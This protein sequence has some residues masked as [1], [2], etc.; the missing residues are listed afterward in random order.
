MKIENK[1]EVNKMENDIKKYLF[2]LTNDFA[3]FL[4]RQ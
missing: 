2:V 1:E 3:L 4:D